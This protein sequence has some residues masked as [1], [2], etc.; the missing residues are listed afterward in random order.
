LCTRLT[1]HRECTWLSCNACAPHWCDAGGD[2]HQDG[3]TNPSAQRPLQALRVPPGLQ[4]RSAPLASEASCKRSIHR[5]VSASK[6][7]LSTPVSSDCLSL[8]PRTAPGGGTVGCSRRLSTSALEVACRPPTKHRLQIS[9][10]SLGQALVF[11]C[12]ASSTCRT[13]KWWP[14]RRLAAVPKSK[15]AEEG[16]PGAAQCSLANARDSEVGV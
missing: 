11:A 5:S 13:R 14:R 6:R 2:L 15:N 4:A 10:I 8:A 3:C 12:S 9:R 16:R 1:H 7:R